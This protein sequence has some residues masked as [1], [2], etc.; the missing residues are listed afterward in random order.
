MI[1]DAEIIV[2]FMPGKKSRI[3]LPPIGLRIIKSAVAVFLC[4]IVNL[5]RG[6]YGLVFYSQL[7]ALWCMQ[8]YVSETKNKA[9]QRTIGTVVGALYG[10]IMVLI[11]VNIPH[12]PVYDYGIKAVSISL[13]IVLI[14]YTTVL[15]KKKDASYFSCV[16]FLSIVVNHI[17][18]VNPYIFILNRVLDTLIGIEIGLFIN[19]FS[20]P[21]KRNKDILFLSGLDETLLNKD[22]NMSGYSRVELNRMIDNGLQFTI[23]TMRTPASLLEPMKDIRLKL[24]VVVMDGAALYDI[25]EKHFEKVYVI[26]VDESRH[27]ESFF[28]INQVNYFANIIVDDT[29][30]IY[31]SDSENSV[32]NTIVDELRKSPYR[33]YIKRPVPENENVVYFMCIEKTEKIS[34]LISKLNKEGITSQLKVLSYPSTEYAGYS[35]IKIYNHNATKEN[36][37]EYLKKCTSAT[38][39]ETFGTIKGRYTHFINPGDTNRVVKIIKKEFGG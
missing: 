15:I 18:D 19:I 23:V 26:S 9:V 29:V 10:L 33:N 1:L 32:Y 24:P 35:Y 30:L 16:V 21:K 37:I 8:D 5:L 22:N 11:D 28:K 6:G 36:M 12:F 31:Y 13:F 25:K 38:K 3:N 2:K 14:I 34:E 7:A 17:G 27:I 4:Y 39:I 20:M